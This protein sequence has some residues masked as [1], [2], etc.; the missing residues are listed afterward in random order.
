M[1]NF[2]VTEEVLECM[3]SKSRKTEKFLLQ[4]DDTSI[5]EHY[6]ANRIFA[7]DM[8][9]LCIFVINYCNSSHF[10][11]GLIPILIFIIQNK[12]VFNHEKVN[13]YEMFFMFEKI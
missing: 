6:L 1:F 3:V 8:Y 12:T 9:R 4:C 10:E 11:G 13:F 5:V 7:R 2:S